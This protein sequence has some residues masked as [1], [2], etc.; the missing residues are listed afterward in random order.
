[1]FPD[2]LENGFA[3]ALR[4]C[5][6]RM[7]NFEIECGGLVKVEGLKNEVLEKIENLVKPIFG[8]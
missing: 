6:S 3:N 2:P 5:E 1:M 8:G 4:S 7:M